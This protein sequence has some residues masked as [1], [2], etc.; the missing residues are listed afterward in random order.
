MIWII[1]VVV[2][3][4]VISGLL[5]FLKNIKKVESR[6]AQGVVQWSIGMAV[7]GTVGIIIGILLVEFAGYSY[8]LP[9]VLWFGGMAIGQLSGVLYNKYKKEV[10][11]E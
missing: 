6:E 10:Q 1:L 2:L 8:P 9:F 11:H 5:L 3:A 7:G 4:L